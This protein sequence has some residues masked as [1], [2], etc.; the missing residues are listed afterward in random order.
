LRDRCAGTSKHCRPATIRAPRS[1]RTPSKIATGNHDTSAL[2]QQFHDV[3]V[4]A[5]LALARPPKWKAQGKGRESPRV[6]SEVT[7]HSLRHTAT[8]AAQECR[9]VRGRGPRQSSVTK[10]RPFPGIIPHRRGIETQALAKLPDV[11]RG[12]ESR[13]NEPVR[14]SNWDCRLEAG[15]YLLIWPSALPIHQMTLRL[16]KLSAM[17]ALGQT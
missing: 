12:R 17:E 16:D 4:S 15:G 3:L 6:R 11:R 9:R 7:F 13:P 14:T 1:S 5:G 2:S 8:L 10:A